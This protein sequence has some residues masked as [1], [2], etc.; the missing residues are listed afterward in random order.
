MFKREAYEKSGG[1][2]SIK[3]HLVDDI[4]MSK[5]IKKSGYKFMVYD[6]KNTI[7]CRMYK[8][9]K[10]VVIGLTK[11]IYPAFNGNILALF[12]F[13]GLLSASLL[14][15]FILLP[16]GASLF[17]WPSA[18]IRLMIIQV[19]IILVIKTMLAI[20]YKQKML[21]ILL[22]PVSMAVIDALIFVSFFQAKYGEGLSWKERVYDVS[23][24]EKI[25]LVREGH[26]IS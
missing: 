17:D 11:S 12:L 3:G 4:Q 24:S 5:R 16:L 20:R 6:G 2:E 10:G 15:P 8:N 18:I 1:Y 7:F 19:I 25:K 14:I 13:T 9:L 22:A 26:M 23:E 21:D